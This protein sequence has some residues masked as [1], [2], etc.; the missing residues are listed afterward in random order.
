MRVNLYMC[1]KGPN[2]REHIVWP[3]DSNGGSVVGRRRPVLVRTALSGRC[4]ARTHSFDPQNGLLWLARHESFSQPR[5]AMPVL[6]RRRRRLS[7]LSLGLRGPLAIGP[8]PC[9]P[10]DLPRRGQRSTNGR[11][12]NCGGL[13]PNIFE[14]HCLW[15]SL[16]SSTMQSGTVRRRRRGACS[17][18][19]SRTFADGIA[20]FAMLRCVRTQPRPYATTESGPVVCWHFASRPHCVLWCMSVLAALVS[21]ASCAIC[22]LRVS[23][24]VATLQRCFPSAGRCS[25]RV[26][27]RAPLKKAKRGARRRAAGFSHDPARA[28]AGKPTPIWILAPSTPT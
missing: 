13:G 9:F 2:L 16:C 18:P 7:S 1:C 24:V 21:Y 10:S 3:E 4:S 8:R 11:S 14:Q 23:C 22:V 12:Q 6:R 15:M 5:C 27:A 19:L 26:R 17:T 25:F 28:P 20:P